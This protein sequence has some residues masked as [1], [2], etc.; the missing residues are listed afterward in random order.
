MTRTALGAVLHQVSQTL[1]AREQWILAL[2]AFIEIGA[3]NEAARVRS[4]I[5]LASGP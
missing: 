2:K 1:E 4:L 3:K 5:T